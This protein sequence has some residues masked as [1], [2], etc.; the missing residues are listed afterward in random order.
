[1]TLLNYVTPP[2]LVAPSGCCWGGPMTLL[3]SVRGGPMNLRTGTGTA[4]TF[5]H[6][7]AA[8]ARHRF[9]TP[10]LALAARGRPDALLLAGEL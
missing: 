3:K 7:T 8:A 9:A 6:R 4:R 2:S 10:I 1:M 5:L